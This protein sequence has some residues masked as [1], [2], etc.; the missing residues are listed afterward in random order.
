MIPR[1]LLR[2]TQAAAVSSRATTAAIRSAA[3]RFSPFQLQA[4]KRGGQSQLFRPV[5]VSQSVAGRRWASTE[6]KEAEKKKQEEET[7]KKEEETKKEESKE[8]KLQKEIEEKN[9]EIIALKV[10]N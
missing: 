3:P 2:Q 1:S 7:Q 5:T 6:S 10:R 8:E 4:L 9:K